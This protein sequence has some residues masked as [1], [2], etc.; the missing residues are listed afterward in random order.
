MMNKFLSVLLITGLVSVT[1]FGKDYVIDPSHSSIE[2]KIKHLV[3]KVTGSFTSFTGEF[4]YDEAKPEAFKLNTTI[5]ADS[6]D[7]RNAKRDEHLKSED[8]FNVKKY[9]TLTY[10]GKS[11]KKVGDHKYRVEGDLTMNGKTN[12]V[13]LDVETTEEIM[14]PNGKPVAGGTATGKLNRKDFGIVWNK[15]L[16]K[17]GFV[18]GEEVEITINLEVN[19]KTAEAPVAKPAAP[20]KKK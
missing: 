3:S 18:L 17:G 14:G 19:P 9:P 8:F 16:D 7:T 6:I 12:S 5:K 15:A 1:A 2:F 4:S 11:A 13:P 20:A 10:V